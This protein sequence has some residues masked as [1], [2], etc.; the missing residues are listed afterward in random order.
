MHLNRYISY[1]FRRRADELAVSCDGHELIW[2]DLDLQSQ[3]LAAALAARGVAPGD[4]VGILLGNCV[5]WCVGFLATVRLGAIHVPLNAMFGRFELSQIAAAADCAAVLSTPGLIGG[6]G[7]P[8]GNAA[9]GEVR[10][11]EPRQQ[12]RFTAFA[13]IVAQGESFTDRD[14]S[15]SDPLAICFTSGTT[16]IPKG[17]VLTHKAVATMAHCTA[18]TY[19]LRAGEERFLVLAPLAFTGGVIT[20]L[21]PLLMFGASGWIEKSVDPHRALA[22]L[23]DQKISYF[24]GVPALWDRI[25]LAPDFA[26]A[27][28]THLRCAYTG[29]APVPRALLDRFLGKGVTIRQQYGFTE[30]CG[31]VSAPDRDGAAARPQSCGL[32]YPALEVEVRTPA[33]ARVQPGEVGEIR[34]RGAQLL[35]EYW[36]D[37]IATRAAFDGEWYLSGDLATVDEFGGLIIVDRKKN[38]LISGGVNIYPA[39]VEHALLQIDGVR[40][41]LVFG[42]PSQRWGDEVTALV[43]GQRLSE[44][45]VL[46][47]ARDLLGSYK[48]PKRIILANDPLPRTASG[49][50]ARA[51]LDEL[52]RAYGLLEA[53]EG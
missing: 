26:G 10:L 21:V 40:E 50:I 48:A 8:A 51:R 12:F 32:P 36:R 2:R 31:G 49:K 53:A 42:V 35:K 16:G 25:A 46:V 17:A 9:A 20:N 14:L 6:I 5:E 34:V 43:Y 29:G 11:Y 37:P 39:E 45:A 52:K 38:M 18:L 24:G 27:D 23:I 22:L 30:A 4:R 41:A 33:G 7:G 28:L 19:G 15:E 47:Q 44:Q 13:Q 3:A 1:W